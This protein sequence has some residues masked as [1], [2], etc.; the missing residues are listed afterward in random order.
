[1]VG[2]AR[3]IDAVID[4]LHAPARRKRGEMVAVDLGAG[5][6][7]VARGELL[8]LLPFRGSPDVLGMRR[9]APR[10]PEQH[11]SVA[12]HGRGR[13]Q[14]M[15]VQPLDIARQLGG[16]HQRLPEAADAIRGRVAS[17]VAQPQRKG[18]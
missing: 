10:Q 17:E 16:E 18:F 12:R 2:K 3:E 15:R 8:A 1:M 5:D 9:A 14:E 11:G 6:E 4:E 13:V 7:P